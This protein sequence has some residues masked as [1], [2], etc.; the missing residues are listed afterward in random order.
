MAVGDDELPL[1]EPFEV[2]GRK[3]VTV[4]QPQFMQPE[5]RSPSVAEAPQR[6][7]R[8]KTIIS[9]VRPELLNRDLAQWN[10]GYLVNMENATR[11]KQQHKLT[12]QAKKNA[13]FWV[14]GQGIGKVGIGLGS[15]RVPAPLDVFSGDRLL[16]A[17]MGGEVGRKHAR[18][19][20]GESESDESGRRVRAREERELG[21]GEKFMS[22][23]GIGPE[24]A[25]VGIQLSSCCLSA[26]H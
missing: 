15:E 25:E 21:R 13:A 1:A 14:L 23:E 3:E 16:S 24:F 8:I 17:L 2:H 4:D 10:E 22:D 6:R 18:S 20:S 7:R 11:L 26:L 9:D 12:A 5:Q 19:T